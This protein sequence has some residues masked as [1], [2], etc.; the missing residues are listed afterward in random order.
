VGQALKSTVNFGGGHQ[1]RFFE[2]THGRVIVSFVTAGRPIGRAKGETVD[3]QG[4][5]GYSGR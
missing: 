5:R 1:L 4:A 2:D 3:A